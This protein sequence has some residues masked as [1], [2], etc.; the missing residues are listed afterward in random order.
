MSR[1]VRISLVFF[2]SLALL[3][4][5]DVALAACT[6]TFCPLAE[7]PAGSKLGQLYNSTTDFSSFIN[8]SFKF[9][10]SLGAILAVLRIAYAGYLYMGSDMWSNKG[11][12]KEVIADVTLGLLLLLAI[13]IILYQINPDIVKMD[14]LRNIQ[15]I[16]T[17][18]AGGASFT[19]ESGML[20]FDTPARADPLGPGEEASF[21]DRRVIPAGAYCFSPTAGYFECFGTPSDCGTE[22]SKTPSARCTAY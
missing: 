18:T 22:A 8:G 14:S 1:S 19:D 4:I 3:A 2:V 10:L 13:Y 5:A 21:T 15:G 16:Q 20:E 12:A 6:A 9:A 7:T 11:K 17:P